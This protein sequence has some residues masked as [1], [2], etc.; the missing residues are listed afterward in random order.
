MIVIETSV[1][2]GGTRLVVTGHADPSTE[3]GRLVCAS[4]S[5]L[6]AT[7]LHLHHGTLDGGAS[8]LVDVV[9]PDSLF[10]WSIAWLEMLRDAYPAHVTIARNDARRTA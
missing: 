4:A 10:E 3:D 1:A 8:G 6:L 2:S 9:L 7:V 5:T